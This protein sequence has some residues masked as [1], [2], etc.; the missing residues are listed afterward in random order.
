MEDNKQSSSTNFSLQR[1]SSN[2]TRSLQSGT[3]QQNNPPAMQSNPRAKG[4]D[5]NNG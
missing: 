4:G 1:E 5:N 3:Q 2:E